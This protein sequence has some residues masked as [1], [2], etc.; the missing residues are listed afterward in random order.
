MVKF[1]GSGRSKQSCVHRK[2][3]NMA[4]QVADDDDQDYEEGIEQIDID[5]DHRPIKKAKRHF[6]KIEWQGDVLKEVEG[7]T[8]YSAAQVGGKLVSAGGY[9]TVEPDQQG[10]PFYIAKVISLWQD[11]KGE[12]F[13]HARWFCRGSDTVLGETC[14]DAKELMI[15][16]E[17]EDCLLSAID[18][19]VSVQ[20]KSIDPV[21]WKAAAGMDDPVEPEKEDDHSGTS[22]WYQFQY[23]SRHGR[24]ETPLADDSVT[25]HRG[26]M[27]C[28]R[29]TALRDRERAKLGTKTDQGY[30]SVTWH[31]MVIKPGDAV[32]LDPDSFQLKLDCVIKK[33]KVAEEEE[34]YDEEA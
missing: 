20:Y 10:I 16:D 1:G 34:T 27:C 2:C 24:F 33:E 6:Y 13:F 30:E 3:P 17:C 14:D 9:V 19:A 23:N 7:F 21:Q 15:L 8:Y 12:K 18:N 5:V 22:F 25:N 26:C 4:V 29:L 32:F 28:D 11:K 31:D